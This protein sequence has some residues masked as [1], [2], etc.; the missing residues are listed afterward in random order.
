MG[1][2]CPFYCIIHVNPK[3]LVN[4]GLSNEDNM[5]ENAK[6]GFAHRDLAGTFTENESG[7]YDCNIWGKG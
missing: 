3:R 1:I 5:D 7:C 2:N 4:I 6:V